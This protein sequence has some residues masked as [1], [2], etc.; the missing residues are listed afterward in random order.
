MERTEIRARVQQAMQESDIR[1][2]RRKLLSSI[3]RGENLL[4]PESHAIP[5]VIVPVLRQTIRQAEHEGLSGE[6]MYTLMA[7][8]MAILIEELELDRIELAMCE[9]NKTVVFAK[10]A[11]AHP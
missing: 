1:T 9:L 8:R 7:Y 6:D 5:T 3:Y 11:E 4:V 2:I 10:D